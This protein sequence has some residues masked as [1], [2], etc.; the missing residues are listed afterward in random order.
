[1]ISLLQSGK[2]ENVNAGLRELDKDG[3][4]LISFE[5]MLRWL[6]WIPIDE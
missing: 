2:K 3:N 6:K 5:E 1:M 4:G